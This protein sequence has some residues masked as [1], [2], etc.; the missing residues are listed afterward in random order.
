[1]YVK[2]RNLHETHM[3][4]EPAGTLPQTIHNYSYMLK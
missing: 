2:V 4:L 3:T 1:M